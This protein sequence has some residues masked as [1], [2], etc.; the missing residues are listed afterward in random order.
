MS[1][2]DISVR[3]RIASEILGMPVANDDRMHC[4]FRERHTRNS[5]PRDMRVCL[6]EDGGRL[7]TFH[8]FHSSCADAWAPLNKALRRAIWFAENGRKPSRGSEWN[9]GRRVA[10]LP[11]GEP[12]KP[13]AFDIEAL[14]RVQRSEIPAGRAFF[15]ERSTV[16][17]EGMDSF[18]FLCHLYEPSERVLVFDRFTSQG[19]YLAWIGMGTYRLGRQ[20]GVKAVPSPL[21]QGGPEGVWFLCQ[22]VDG[23]WHLNPRN[24][25]KETGEIPYSRRAMEAVTSWRYMVLESDNAPPALWLNLL[26]Q[27]PMPIASIYTSGGRS[28]HALMKVPAS[29]KAGWDGYKRFIL[30]VIT[31]LGADPGA[32]SAVRLTRLPFCRRGS[33]MQELLYLN[34]NPDPA[35]IA[36]CDL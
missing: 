19:D 9:S 35:G 7:P 4:R 14:K 22:P 10:Q 30:G 31:K 18:D 3:E 26:A 8:C 20:R 11:Q 17:F 34:P 21:P 24:P 1:T 27:L 12:A 33:K 6:A 25:D 16:D 23:Q 36:I 32:L 28:I 5:G 15:R 2:I 13:R 29:T